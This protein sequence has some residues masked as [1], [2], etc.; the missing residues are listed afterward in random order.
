MNTSKQ[1]I[2]AAALVLL[3]GLCAGA[4][5][6]QLKT[7][8][9]TQA[10]VSPGDTVTLKLNAIEVA[11]GAR[12]FDYNITPT[13][14]RPEPLLREVLFGYSFLG[15]TSGGLP[16]SLSL[17]MNCTPA[18]FTPGGTNEMAGGTWS[19]PVYNNRGVLDAY[20]RVGVFDS[21]VGALY[22]NITGGTINWDKTGTVG[23]FDMTF[24]MTG[25][26]KAFAG[27][28]GKGTLQG[29]LFESEK[30]TTIEGVMT[31]YF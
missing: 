20:Y 7:E 29:T 18:T 8:T 15:R 5:A 6:Q 23:V 24:V 25:G 9:K 21:Y 26:T 2:L 14:L 19:L 1:L 12:A 10:P 31:I 30:G 27:L 17:S 22:G 13:D 16:G 3:A 28:S 4:T 11:E